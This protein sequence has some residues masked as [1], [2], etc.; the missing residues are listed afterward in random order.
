MIPADLTTVF[1]PLGA[2]II[3]TLMGVVVFL[4]KRGERLETS[5]KEE[6][7]AYHKLYLELINKQ[8]EISTKT[9]DSIN[10]LM[11]SYTQ[12]REFNDLTFDII[13]KKLGADDER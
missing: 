9:S 13:R 5:H 6:L 7:H 8:F 12:M 10:Q 11:E 1:D 2:T 3:A 4:W